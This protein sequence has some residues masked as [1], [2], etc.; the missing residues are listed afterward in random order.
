MSEVLDALDR[1]IADLKDTQPRRVTTEWPPA[2]SRL[3]AAVTTVATVTTEKQDI[4]NEHWLP[5]IVATAIT[6]DIFALKVSKI[7]GHSGHGGHSG[8]NPAEISGH[9]LHGGGHKWP[10]PQKSLDAHSFRP[11][12][13]TRDGHLG[14]MQHGE[15]L[16]PGL[17][18]GSRAPIG[19]VGD[20]VDVLAL[21]DGN[22]VHLDPNYR[23]LIAWGEQWRSAAHA[24]VTT[25][26]DENLQP[27]REE[28]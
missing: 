4:Y 13:L 19:D 11:G 6:N 8:G 27:S 18:A 9:L 3:S 2:T 20:G 14:H 22:R 26:W 21:A 23:C 17:C 10:L 1:M 24:A 16:A 5:D 15:R 12:D 7:G 25:L 28:K